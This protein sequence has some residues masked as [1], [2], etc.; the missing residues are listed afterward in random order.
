MTDVETRLR[1]A[2][3]RVR[4][5][6][7]L[8]EDDARTLAE[9]RA[10]VERANAMLEGMFAA[11]P[12]AI[13]ACDRSL[14]VAR[15]NQ[16]AE[17]LVGDAAAVGRSLPEVLGCS[18]L[19]SHDVF[20]VLDGNESKTARFEVSCRLEPEADSFKTSVVAF[21][22]PSATDQVLFVCKDARRERQL[23]QELRQSQ[24]LEAVGALAAGVAHEINTPIQFV[25]D[26]LY[27]L[28]DAFGDMLRAAQGEATAEEADLP[29]LVDEVP[30]ALSRCEE[31]V[32]RVAEIVRALKELSHPDEREKASSDLNRACQNAA[33][34]TRNETKNVAD[35]DLEFGA[36]PPV[37]CHLG[38]VSQVLINLIVNAAHAIEDRSKREGGTRRG[39]IVISTALEPASVRISI[40]DDGVGI[41]EAI[42]E[43][44]FEPFYTT[45][46]V[47]RGTGQG[48]AIA[49]TIVVER[50][51]GELSFDTQVGKGTT[52]HVRLPLEAP[53]SRSSVWAQ[54][55]HA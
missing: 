45:K 19:S 24:K 47:G 23:E 48:L 9:S 41:P 1:E 43:R 33:I 39:R 29:Y 14:R 36:I 38:D 18:G 28:R 13:F 52:F 17:I 37:P 50:H 25:G 12:M 21:V 3:T 20:S 55:P 35:V 8:R 22:P 27:F 4:E 54:Q 15:M 7:R 40:A 6:E 2:E 32:G 10:T 26:S 11:T 5:L 42:R 16:Q 49:R 30:Q 46:A 44:I 51:G 31:G 53:R 34:V